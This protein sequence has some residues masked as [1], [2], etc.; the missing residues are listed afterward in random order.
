ME[1]RREA[2]RWDDQYYN[3]GINCDRNESCHRCGGLMVSQFY[4]DLLNSTGELIETLRR[5][6]C[7][8]VVDPVILR[9]RLQRRERI[10][11]TV[12]GVS[13]HSVRRQGI[14]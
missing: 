3:L 1:K 2:I 8:D 13:V 5:V 4:L 11:P 7:G 12:S 14:A 10:S 9:H 6:Q